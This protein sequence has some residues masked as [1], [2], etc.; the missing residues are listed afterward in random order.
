MAWNRISLLGKWLYTVR[1]DTPATSAIPVHAGSGEAFLG[2][3]FHIDCDLDTLT[4]QPQ[5]VQ[6]VQWAGLPQIL[7]MI[8]DGSFCSFH[9][10]L[11]ELIF[12]LHDLPS[13]F[14]LPPVDASRVEV[15]RRHRLTL[16]L[17]SSRPINLEGYRLTCDASHD[18]AAGVCSGLCTVSDAPSK[19]V[20]AT[21]RRPL[22]STTASVLQVQTSNLWSG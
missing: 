17:A 12:A 19:P 14:T 16:D 13:W 7:S 5:E 20:G 15:A 21:R 4:L 1:F 8:R 18:S 22:N 9:P 2:E 6:A 3:D 11:I 10:S